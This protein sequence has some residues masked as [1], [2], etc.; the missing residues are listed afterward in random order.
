[1]LMKKLS[2]QFWLAMFLIV[3]SI[4]LYS[5]HYV[6]FLDPHHIFIYMLG[7]LAFL[8]IEVLLV[9]VIVH[10]LLS[11]REKRVML[12]K[13]NMVIESFFSEVGTGLLRYFI[14]YDPDIDKIRKELL[15]NTSWSNGD[16]MTAKNAMTQIDHGILCPRGELDKIKEYLR[17]K[18]EFL[19]R[20]LE[21]P[22]ILEH[23]S[24]TDTLWAVFH[25]I[26][27]LL[28]REDLKAVCDKD[29]DHLR[30]DMNR[31]YNALISQWLDYMMHLK[32]SYP[33][34]FSLAAR[35]N[36]FDPDASPEI[37]K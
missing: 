29:L 4:L 14:K 21:N 8:P 19:L 24:F 12:E 30:G 6:I 10:R 31:A 18:R 3:L 5:L 36:P 16:F 9:T 17:E 22:N 20:L 23:E 11:Q 34:L 25:L 27:E 7:D 15:V 26:E 28:Q 1:M 32:N 13:L 33:Y 35:M 2:W 37:T